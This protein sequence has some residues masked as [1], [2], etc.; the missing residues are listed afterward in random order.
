[1]YLLI[2]LYQGDKNTCT[3]ENVL[4]DKLLSE[5]YKELFPAPPPSV[6]RCREQWVA[7]VPDLGGDNW[8]DMWCLPFTHLVSAWDRLIQFTFFT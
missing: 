4:L 1:M 7:E 2:W 5:F 8:D 3:L 6:I